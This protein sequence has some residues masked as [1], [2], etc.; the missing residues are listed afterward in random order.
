MIESIVMPFTVGVATRCV[1]LARV[2]CVHEPLATAAAANHLTRLGIHNNRSGWWMVGILRVR[3]A[4]V[5]LARARACRAHLLRCSQRVF[6]V[7]L[8]RRPLQVTGKPSSLLLRL[9]KTIL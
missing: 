3:M 1:K 5:V 4:A 9:C 6:P 8:E 7:L 2:S